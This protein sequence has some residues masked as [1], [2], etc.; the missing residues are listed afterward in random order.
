MENKPYT[1]T[2]STV[3]LYR[4]R[5][6]SGMYWADITIDQ[7]DEAGRISIASD[8]GNWS[9]YWGCCGMPF[10]DF[11]CKIDQGYAANKFGANDWFDLEATIK[12]LR[13]EVKRQLADR[14]IDTE[15]AKTM[16]EEISELTD[17]NSKDAFAVQC[18]NMEHLSQLYDCG[19]DLLTDV[20]PGFKHFW[21]KVWPVMIET[22]KAEKV[23]RCRRMHTVS[24]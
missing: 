22:F 24:T 4:L 9:N 19:P 6:P 13:D 21:D 12:H 7:G 10:K 11:L 16:R 23:A 20:E 2:K 17:Y 8:F 14:S 15:M 1:V 3:E 5:H 18:F